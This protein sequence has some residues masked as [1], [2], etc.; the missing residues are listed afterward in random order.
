MDGPARFILIL[1]TGA[2]GNVGLEVARQLLEAGHAVRA[3]VTNPKRGLL[4]LEA[5]LGTSSG[6]EVARF[7]LGDASTY[8][9][10]FTGCDAC[11]LMRPPAVSDTKRMMLPA[12]DAG[13]GSGVR[14]WVFLSLQGAERNSIV[15]HA[16]VEKHLEALA[17]DGKVVFTFLRAAFFMQ[18]LS[19]THREDIRE[20]SDLTIPAGDGRTAFV[21][22]RDVAAV[23]AKALTV[24][25][26]ELERL[27]LRNV[28]VELTGD[29]ALTYGE[30]AEILTRILGRTITYSNPSNLAFGLHLRRKGMPLAQ[31]LV[32]EAL[33]TVA[34]LGRAAHLSTEVQ[35][36]LGRPPIRFEAFA[37]D[38]AAAWAP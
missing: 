15:P 38:H 2:T 6:L 27:A 4:Q 26:G 3:A 17:R 29:E 28:G 36:I 19:T 14:R 12:I 33:Y 9:P 10:V 23:G 21:D 8:E 25:D 34:K 16:A 13:V 11:F 1:V 32:M 35:R 37:R 7:E 20:R 24:S 5:S 30:V 18:N 31:I 22:V